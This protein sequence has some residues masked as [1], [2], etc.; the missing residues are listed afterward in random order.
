MK[1]SSVTTS[2]LSQWYPC[3]TA[4]S[5]CTQHHIQYSNSKTVILF[6]L[7]AFQPHT[8]NW[9]LNFVWKFIETWFFAP[10][11]QIL[12]W[13]FQRGHTTHFGDNKN[14]TWLIFNVFFFNL[15]CGSILTLNTGLYKFGKQKSS[16]F[17]TRLGPHNDNKNN[18]RIKT[19]HS[20]TYNFSTT[21]TEW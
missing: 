8:L 4:P 10:E 11:I 9:F 21:T 19:I 13:G 6:H 2:C 16:I 7:N 20:N 12:R 1:P 18:S 3:C 5:H 17:G 14:N 15:P